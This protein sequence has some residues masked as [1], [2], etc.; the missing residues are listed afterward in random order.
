MSG[1]I[2]SDGSALVEMN[3]QTMAR[4]GQVFS[5][6]TTRVLA[7]G[8]LMTGASLFNPANS[9]KNILVFSIKM[10]LNNGL[11]AGHATLTTTDP[12]LGTAMNVYNMKAG[13]PTSAIA[14][15]LSYVNGAATQSGNVFDFFQA[16]TADFR[17][18]L[19]NFKVILLPAGAANGVAVFPSIPA[20]GYWAVT[21]TYAEY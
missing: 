5:A 6:T 10:G 8:A 18:M 12:A 2:N 20:S 9:G 3:T 1:F 16:P 4:S 13:G 19:S 7:S 17:E 21:F 14:G 11:V 15:T